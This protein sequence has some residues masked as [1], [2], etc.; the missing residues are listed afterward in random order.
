MGGAK[1]PSQKNILPILLLFPIYIFFC[2]FVTR[3]GTF[4]SF[5]LDHFFQ[6]LFLSLSTGFLISFIISLIKN[7][8]A[9]RIVI[10]TL[11]FIIS[12][13]CSSQVVYFEIFGNYYNWA[14]VG[15][16]GE[17]ATQ[18]KDMFF[19]GIVNSFG[20]LFLL[21][22]PMIAVSVFNGRLTYYP[23]KKTPLMLSVLC[24][25]LT[26]LFFIFT[27]FGISADKQYQ[28][29]LYSYLYPDSGN[30]YLNFGVIT[31]SRLNIEQL[32]FGKREGGIYDFGDD[33]T[34]NTDI[35]IPSDTTSGGT[36]DTEESGEG[37]TVAPPPEIEYGDNVLEI[38]FN[39]LINGEN[40][41]NIKK[42]HQYFSTVTPTKKNEYT[43][44]FEGK[45]LIF[46]TLEGFSGKVIS[47]ELTPT[48]YKMANEG[49]VFN[50]YYHSVWAGSTLTGEHANITG[51]IYMT[52]SCL[53]G[54]NGQ[55]YQPFVLGN[56][57]KNL[58]YNTYY[59]HGHTYDYSYGREKWVPNMGYQYYA[60]GN[61]L[62]AFK[63]KDG[64]TIK[65]QWPNSDHEV[66]KVTI[67]K[68]V[69]ESPFHIY[70][71]SISGHANYNFLG[72][73][74]MS[75]KHK[76]EVENLP[77][78]YTATKAYI[79]C[80]LEVELMVKELVDQLDAAGIL[81]DTVFVMAPDHFPYGIKDNANEGYTPEDALSDLYGLPAK[82]IYDNLE[83]YRNTL[84]IWSS[85]M[86][87]PITVDTPCSA[88]DILPTVSNLFGIEYDS[89]L[90]TGTDI[91]SG[92][93]PFVIIKTLNAGNARC[94]VS[95]YGSYT[96]KQGFVPASG[97]TVDE[98]G[99]D[100]YVKS[101]NDRLK[102]RLNYSESI[103]D[104]NYYSYL[105]D[106]LN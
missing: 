103:V 7:R 33:I 81:D 23:R 14:D 79:A 105:K 91:F 12:L 88:I 49:F 90:I 96:P 65:K 87:E 40:N 11:A 64:N 42:L 89:R 28:G 4:G 22:L 104:Y 21:F 75:S 47:P 69:G 34:V 97:Y 25:A 9:V 78:K 45:N 1:K 8:T 15:M 86:D 83:L 35:F 85:S 93:D 16:A 73:N 68:F 39:A 58:G 84:I 55:N 71:M 27:S 99:I 72:G 26:A 41:K 10:I 59:F 24:L 94:W 101:M 20:L 67:D 70:Y 100:A 63:D 66:A 92:T 52:T 74:K 102:Q 62:E 5:E 2:E 31:S 29:R 77:Y 37:T 80:Q 30:T 43:G 17:A 3:V 51:N 56:Q 19:D 48:L 13:L 18:F 6:I 53:K 32:I 106:Y 61:G 82:D 46:I 38:D 60:M 76:A 54:K 57:F 44:M 50:N 36:S 98:S 95:R